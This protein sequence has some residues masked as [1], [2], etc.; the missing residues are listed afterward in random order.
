MNLALTIIET[1]RKEKA[2]EI[3]G[4]EIAPAATGMAPGITGGG[5][6]LE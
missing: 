3:F 4:R 1:L 2:L 5:D 6:G